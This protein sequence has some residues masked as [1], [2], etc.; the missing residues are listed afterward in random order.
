MIELCEKPP[1][2]CNVDQQ[3]FK[4]YLARWM[5]VTVQM[6]PFT[7]KTIM[8]VLQASAKAAMLQCSG[9]GAA[10][11]P[12]TNACGMRWTNGATWDG[13][14]GPGQQMAALSVLL[15]TIIAA[16][17]APLTNSTGGTSVSDPTAGT[18]KT[19]VVPGTVV[20][21]ATT[22][23]RVGAWILTIL[24]IG[25]S[26]VGCYFLWSPSWEMRPSS[27]YS[28]GPAL[29]TGFFASMSGGLG[30]SAKAEKTPGHMGGLMSG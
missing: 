18:N 28:T 22:G 24:L 2:S 29:R 14:S 11:A 5:A 21:P 10:P 26:V 3:T 12:L 4:T 20:T 1:N 7:E 13:S 25:S 6:A 8:P 9:N 15:S 27:P 19:D 23:G 16:T 17:P 30:S